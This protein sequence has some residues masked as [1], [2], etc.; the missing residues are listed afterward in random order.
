MGGHTI[1]FSPE[2]NTMIGIRG[3]GKS[4]VLESLRYALDIPLG[5]KS[6]DG[7]I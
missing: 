3:S 2:L 1:E 7:E 4:S 5:E 6:V